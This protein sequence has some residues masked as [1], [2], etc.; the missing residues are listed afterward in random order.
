MVFQPVARRSVPDE[1]FAQMLHA[2]IDG[3]VAA[4][5]ALP[6]ERALAE[7][8]GVSRPA[9]REAL[10][11]M[12]QA[13]LVDVRQ[14]DGTVVRDFRR[15]AG[16]DLLP[17]LLLRGETVD[18]TVVRDI[19]DA[20]LLIGPEV[21]ALAAA[22]AGESLARPL[23]DAIDALATTEDPVASQRHAL[24]FWDHLVDGADSIVFR[25]VFNSLRAAYEPALDLLGPLMAAEVSRT[26]AY[27]AL[28]DAVTEADPERARSAALDL[29]SPAT[30]AFLTVIKELT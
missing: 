11:R 16:L 9:V 19:L 24:T 27:R 8:L 7:V 20:R 13:G 15:S 17:R 22:R 5:E 10:Q 28:A 29:L 25:L 3:S 21:A 18:L 23:S 6:S 30:E 12:S 2:V 1:V 26:D 4:G 14:G